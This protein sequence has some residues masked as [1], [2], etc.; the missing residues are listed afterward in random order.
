MTSYDEA[1]LRAVHQVGVLVS[2]T[3]LSLSI[4]FAGLWVW[5]L[6]VR[7]PC[8]ERYVRLLDLSQILVVLPFLVALG[9][10]ALL[11][12]CRTAGTHTAA[13]VVA[14]LVAVPLALGC[15]HGVRRIAF[16]LTHAVDSTCWTF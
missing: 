2:G 15:V 14:I 16:D 5:D 13:T 1:D 12:R 8:P 10:A 9:V 3:A 11:A 6:G 4:A 7:P